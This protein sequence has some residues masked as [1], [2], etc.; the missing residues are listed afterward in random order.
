MA[1]LLAPVVEGNGLDADDF[2]P[3]Y[4]IEISTAVAQFNRRQMDGKLAAAIAVSQPVHR[5]PSAP[6]AAV[7]G[8]RVA[9]RASRAARLSGR[10][11]RGAHHCRH[12]RA[13][14]GAP[15]VRAA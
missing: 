10:A 15:G 5:S 9:D 3:E 12:W 2:A 11:P 14:L 7:L 8:V 6:P 1:S 4:L 13:T